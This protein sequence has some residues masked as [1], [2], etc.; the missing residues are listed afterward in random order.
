MRLAATGCPDDGHGARKSLLILC[1]LRKAYAC[2]LVWLFRCSLRD[3]DRI[4]NGGGGTS[5][6]PRAEC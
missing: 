5:D 4:E 2:I 1:H 6:S 3:P